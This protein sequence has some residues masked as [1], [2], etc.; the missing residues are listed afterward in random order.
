MTLLKTILKKIS[1]EIVKDAIYSKVE[2]Y[3][4]DNK[5]AGTKMVNTYKKIAFVVFG[6][7]SNYQNNYCYSYD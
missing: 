7:N 6:F 2:V 1:T 5:A 3:V 4:L